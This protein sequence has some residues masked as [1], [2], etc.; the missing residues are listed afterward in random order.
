MQNMRKCSCNAMTAPDDAVNIIILQ[1]S[2]EIY[3]NRTEIKNKEIIIN[4]GRDYVLFSLYLSLLKLM[5]LKVNIFFV[6]NIIYTIVSVVSVF[7]GVRCKDL[8]VKT[9]CETEVQLTANFETT[10]LLRP[11]LKKIHGESILNDSQYTK[12]SG[13]INYVT[14][15][16]IIL[17]RTLCTGN[18][19][20]Y[21]PFIT[22]PGANN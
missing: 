9:K 8:M 4:V 1:K 14:V 17:H 15:S 12:S 22:T 11:L 20:A 19:A 13:K 6:N 21:D 7:Q 5:I 18:D 3:S 2:S 10:P 16:C